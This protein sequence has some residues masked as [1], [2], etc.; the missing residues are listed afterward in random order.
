MIEDLDSIGI[1]IRFV[2]IDER[3]D[4]GGPDNGE[5]KEKNPY[6]NQTSHEFLEG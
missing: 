4:F 3:N 1:E 6:D 2:N 5:K